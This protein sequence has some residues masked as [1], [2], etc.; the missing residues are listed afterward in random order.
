MCKVTDNLNKEINVVSKKY[1]ICLQNVVEWK[2][3]IAKK[4]GNTQ[5]KYKDLNYIQVHYLDKYS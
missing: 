5:V 2:Y 4:N 1:N 3:R